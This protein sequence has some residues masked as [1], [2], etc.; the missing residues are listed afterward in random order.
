MNAKEK[1]K[2]LEFKQ[3]VEQ[4]H[5]EKATLKTTAL[6]LFKIKEFWMSLHSGLI[7]S[8]PLSTCPMNLGLLWYYKVN[9]S[10]EKI[11]KLWRK[12][13][14]SIPIFWLWYLRQHAPPVSNLCLTN[15]LQ[16]WP[17]IYQITPSTDDNSYRCIF[18]SA[19]SL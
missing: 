13:E 19:H 10:P 11:R 4:L 2:L 15:L 17:T 7:K 18:V 16:L 3:L 5:Q 8:C 12:R 6:D 9:M 14:N 1:C